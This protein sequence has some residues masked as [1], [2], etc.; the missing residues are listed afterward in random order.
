MYKIVQLV[1]M[2]MYL[3]SEA[4]AMPTP[5]CTVTAEAVTFGT[6]NTMSTTNESANSRVQIG[7]TPPPR[8][9]YTILLSTGSSGAYTSRE[10]QGS[11]GGT[12]MYNFYTDAAHT[13]IFGDGSSGTHVVTKSRACPQ[14]RPCE[15][16]VY[17][18]LPLPQPS[19]LVGAYADVVTVT[20]NY[21]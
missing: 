10:M 21:N 4:K 18:L 11:N 8:V 12:L 3:S 1:L 2:S 16:I 17:G 19:A 13:Q 5:T 15:E 20:V 14:Q 7:C 6:I 9:T